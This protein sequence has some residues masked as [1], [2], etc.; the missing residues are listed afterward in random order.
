[1][2]RERFYRARS[3]VSCYISIAKQ[4]VVDEYKE[5]LGHNPNKLNPLEDLISRAYVLGTVLFPKSPILYEPGQ[6][7]NYLSVIPKVREGKPGSIK[8]ENKAI[9]IFG[10]YL[11]LSDFLGVNYKEKGNVQGFEN[12][13]V[14][15]PFVFASNH[16]N[17]NPFKLDPRLLSEGH[18]TNAPTLKDAYMHDPLKGFWQVPV[19]EKIIRDTI[20]EDPYRRIRFVIE[21]RKYILNGIKNRLAELTNHRSDPILNPIANYVH[22]MTEHIMANMA[23]TMDFLSKETDGRQIVSTLKKEKDILGVFPSGQAEYEL[24]R[25]L[26][27]AGGVFEIAAK[28]NTEVLPV[29][30]W[31]D[32]IEIQVRIGKPIK[33]SEIEGNREDSKQKNADNVMIAIGSMLPED[34]WG[35]YAEE[36]RRLKEQEEPTLV[37]SAH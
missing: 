25:G 20:P 18:D 31:F 28:H 21:V 6:I 11:G 26:P 14:D 32:G 3:A 29:A 5:A 30:C 27:E 22:G 13:P 2:S 24:K 23:V 34:M 4:A 19:I 36:I 12:I 37:F 15:R 7:Y 9:E 10:H 1:M 33:C 16:W 35:V 8:L 17:G